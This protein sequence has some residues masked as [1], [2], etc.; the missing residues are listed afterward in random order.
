MISYEINCDTLALIP[1]SEKETKIIERNNIFNVNN[2]VMNII[3]NS[4][5]YFGSSY[6]GRHEGTKKLIGITHKAP[7]IIE[8][9]KNLIYFPTTSPRLENCIWI[10]LNNIKT[11]ERKN[12]K[13]ELQFINN[14][15]LR[16]DISFGSLDNQVLRA[17]KLESV[18]RKRINTTE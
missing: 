6:L 4:C 12:G 16:L 3:E 11:Y 5:E 14:Q 15:K 1:V 7:I 2:S 18:L 10:A 9:S 13:T 8:E 17:T